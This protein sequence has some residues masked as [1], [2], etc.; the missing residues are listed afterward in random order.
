VV[1]LGTPKGGFGVQPKIVPIK[2]GHF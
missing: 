1:G 2:Q